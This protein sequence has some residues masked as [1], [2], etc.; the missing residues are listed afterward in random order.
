MFRNKGFTLI[1]LLVVVA[2]IGLL[3]SVVYASLGDVREKARDHAMIKQCGVLV[4]VLYS[5]IIDGGLISVPTSNTNG[6]GHI[7]SDQTFIGVLWPK[8]QNGW[9]WNVIPGN[10]VE[11]QTTSLRG[12]Y[13]YHINGTETGCTETYT[14]VEPS[15][16]PPVRPS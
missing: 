7:C 5:C 15:R 14:P 1:E 12:A 13:F 8:P 6:G 4:P 11:F 9:E 16:P 2:I 3:S 10:T